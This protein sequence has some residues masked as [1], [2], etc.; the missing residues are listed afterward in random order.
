MDVG[1]ATGAAVVN[2]LL[3]VKTAQVASSQAIWDDW[4]DWNKDMLWFDTAGCWTQAADLYQTIG[5]ATY[6][7]WQPSSGGWITALPGDGVKDDDT[8]WG[9]YLAQPSG[10]SI[11]WEN[12]TP[13]ENYLQNRIDV[14]RDCDKDCQKFGSGLTVACVL[15]YV[16]TLI[17]FL[18]S[19]IFFT[20]AWR[21][22][23]RVISV[24]CSV[25]ACFL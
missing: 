13:M 10:Y 2:L 7:N 19:I 23:G 14:R 6:V 22:M 24:Y 15:N 8:Y 21:P 16:S 17:I 11:D 18:N 4:E 1:D 12:T 5:E 20:G 9:V 3:D 25:G